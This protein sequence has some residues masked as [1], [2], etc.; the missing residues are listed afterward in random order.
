LNPFAGKEGF[1]SDIQDLSARFSYKIDKKREQVAFLN[2]ESTCWAR[3]ICV[4]YPRLVCQIFLQ[5]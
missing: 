2:L 3:K 4:E 1:V 5:N